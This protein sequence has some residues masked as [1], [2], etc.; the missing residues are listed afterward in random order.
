MRFCVALGPSFFLEVAKLR[1]LRLLWSEV[2]AAY[3]GSPAS[4]RVHLHA[5]TSRWN[6]TAFDPHVNLLRGTTEALAAVIGGVDSLHIAP[7]DEPLR[8][9]TELS[10]RVARNTQLVLAEECEL[11]H[12]A[13]PAGGSYAV[14]WLTDGLARRGWE[15]FQQVEREGGMIAALVAGLPQRA[16]VATA[17][18]KREALASRHAVQIGSNIFPIA[19]ETLLS[20]EGPRSEREA[21]QRAE[22]QADVADQRA[23]RVEKACAAALATYREARAARA[24]ITVERAIEAL[25]AGATLA[26]LSGDDGD[27][28]AA[29]EALPARRAAA[30][31][32]ALRTAALGYAKKNGAPPRL[33]Q[34]NIGRSRFYRARAD[35]TTGFF[36]VGGFEV[37]ADAEFETV[38]QAVAAALQSGAELVVI[39]SSDERYAEL[40]APLARALGAALPKARIMLAG[41]AAPPYEAA[42]R[43]AGIET[44]VNVHT[45]AH[46]LLSELL[47][48]IGALP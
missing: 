3:G 30:D 16:V 12:V 45:N 48:Q 29:I 43:E 4:A 47:A 24:P 41:P 42:W 46:A 2:V 1:A 8:R 26:E 40:A 37:L 14:E 38:D 11:R 44:F 23:R 15:L 19:G 31:F 22:R 18:A 13:D 33:F 39:T 27:E 10:R 17:T 25:E 21:E 7:F 6:K 9:A 36:Q 5:R 35:W 34:A 32:E 20:A 28:T